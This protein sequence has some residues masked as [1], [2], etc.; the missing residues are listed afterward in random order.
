MKPELLIKLD[1]LKDRRNSAE[2]FETMALYINAYRDFGQLLSDSVGIKAD[3]EFQYSKQRLVKKVGFLR[4]FQMRR[5]RRA[6][7][8]EHHKLGTSVF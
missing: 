1:Y 4:C 3:F 6:M 7:R 2:I 5:R 8:L